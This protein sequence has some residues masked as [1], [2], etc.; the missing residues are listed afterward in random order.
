LIDGEFGKLDVDS[1]KRYLR[2][3]QT[4]PDPVCIEPGDPGQGDEMTV[5][6]VIAEPS[7][8]CLWAAVGPPSRNP[9]QGYSFTSG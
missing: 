7:R 1:L 9:Y 5:A 2:D 6:S 3:R 4:Y 8:G